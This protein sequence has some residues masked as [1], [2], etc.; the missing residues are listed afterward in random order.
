[1]KIF[2]AHCDVLSKLLENPELDF[3]HER[4]RLD[5][6]LDRM[7][8]ANI[9]VQNFAIYLSERMSRQF[10]FV[11]DSIDLFCQ[12]ILSNPQMRFVRSKNDLRRVAAEGSIGAMLSLEGVDALQEN[13]ANVRILFYLGVRSVGITWN[14]ANWAADGVLEPRRGGLTELGRNLVKECNRIGMILDVSHLSERGFWELAELSNKPF[15]ASHSNVYAVRQHPR[16]L[17][18]EQIKSIIS[19]EGVMGITFVSPFV[20]AVQPVAIDK[21]LPH[22][23]RV[24]SLGGSRHLGLGSDFDGIKEWMIGLEHAGKYG[25]LVELLQKHYSE[26]DVKRFVYGNWYDFYSKHLPD[27]QAN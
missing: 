5:V 21:L 19:S 11:L 3:V 4:H 26:S 24:C 15:I 14:Y 8:E 16:N 22:I 23:D 9:G 25:Q 10:Q 2:D 6:T 18:D 1:M 13:L 12:R 20:D 7:V 17:N 27:G